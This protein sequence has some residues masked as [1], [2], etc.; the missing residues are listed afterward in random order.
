MSILVKSKVK[1]I[2]RNKCWMKK[3]SSEQLDR[4]I[5]EMLEDVANIIRTQHI[6]DGRKKATAKD[7]RDAVSMHCRKEA[8]KTIIGLGDKLKNIVVNAVEE[9]KKEVTAYYGG[10]EQTTLPKGTKQN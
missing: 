9:Q 2:F 5:A 1:K 6:R 7:V 4:S 10:N 3:N 8:A